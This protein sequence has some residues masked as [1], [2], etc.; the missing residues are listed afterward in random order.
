MSR[1]TLRKCKAN[2][3][4]DACA[5]L[6]SDDNVVED[7]DFSHASDTCIWLW[8]ACRNQVRRNNL[9]YG[10]RIKPGT[11]HAYDSACVLVEAGSDNNRFEHNDM[12]HGGD[13][14]YVR[15]LGGWVSR[16][17][18]F[19]DNDA[20]FAHNNCF[21]AQS[22]GNTYRRNKANYGSHGIW[23]G[24]S[25]ETILE[26]NDACYNGVPGP[27][28]HDNAPFP[29]T[30]GSN[31]AVQG[32]GGIIF[33]GP[34]NHTVCRGNKCVGNNG[35][36]IPPSATPRPNPPTR[37]S[38]GP[39]RQ[40][41]PRQS[42]GRLPIRQRLDRHGRQPLPEQPGRRFP[43]GRPRHEHHAARRRSRHHAAAAGR[44]EGAVGGRRGPS[45]RAGRRG[46][47]RPGRP[48]PGLPLGPGRRHD[49]H[50]A[51]Q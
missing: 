15:A 47:R 41:H 9:S 34:S 11:V 46:E 2:R 27:P 8:T 49:R 24:M 3:V 5:L 31:R 7:N 12:T 26:G 21:E 43:Q 1:T 37:P 6:N 39:R 17:N 44:G 29:F 51:A 19:E 40:R 36:G 16:G 18:V 35:A 42:L 50:R 13:G 20:S 14:V 23:V 4:W 22:P 28:G 30:I 32:H 38:T 10:L 48:S 45:V 33:V 25:N